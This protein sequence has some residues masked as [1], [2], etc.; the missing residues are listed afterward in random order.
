M[1]NRKIS[2]YKY[3]RLGKSWRYCKPVI[4][5]NN[6]IKPNWVIIPGG[7]EEYHDE[8]A[9][10]LN[11]AGQWKC[12]GT[13]PA[14]AVAARKR[15]LVRLAAQAEGLDV[16]PD[17]HKEDKQ[18]GSTLSDAITAYLNHINEAVTRGNRRPRTYTNAKHILGEFQRFSKIHYLGEV[19]KQTLFEY[20]AWAKSQ[21]PSGSARTAQNKFIRVNQFFKFS[22]INIAKNCDGPR[23]PKNPPVDV[24]D[25]EQIK[26]FFAA[27]RVRA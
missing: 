19:T 22:G 16:Q 6:K 18:S 1:A 8:G 5:A 14:E 17:T 11:I 10:Y 21:S 24:Y 13:N 20:V 9:Y 4:G 12:V 15:E 2:I 25:D 27:W 3:V 7:K 23:V 26:K